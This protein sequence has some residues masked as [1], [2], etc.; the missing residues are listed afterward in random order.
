M[1]SEVR[2][3]ESSIP[4][5]LIKDLL[6]VHYNTIGVFQD[7]EDVDIEFANWLEEPLKDGVVPP[8]QEPLKIPVTFRVEKIR[9]E[10]PVLVYNA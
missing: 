5:S 6:V 2:W 10:A 4:L 9:K 8:W 3:I 1:N 7:N